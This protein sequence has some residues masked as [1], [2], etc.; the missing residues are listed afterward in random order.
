MKYLSKICLL[1]AVAL[2]ALLP[3]VALS[4]HVSASGTATMSLSPASTALAPGAS[5]NVDI[6]EDSGSDTVNAVQANLSYSSNLTFVSITSSPAFSI[7]AQ[8]S[9][10]GGSVKIGRGTSTPVSGD[11]IIATV[12]FTASGSGTATINFASGSAV[13]RS[14]DN[15]AEALTYN[16]GS[17][18]ISSNA[19]LT[20]SPST[21][22]V[23][24]GDNFDVSVYGDSGSAAVN[25]VQVNL[26][27]PSN[28]LTFVSSAGNTTTWPIE[29][30]NTGGSGTVKIGRGTTSPVSGKQL[31]ATVTFKA[32]AAGTASVAFTSGTGMVSSSDNTAVPSTNTGGIYTLTTSGTS[33]GGSTSG[34]GSTSTKS[35][36]S[37][38]TGSTPALPQS[39]TSAPASGSSPTTQAVDNTG[40]IISD[41]NVTDATADSATINWTTSEPA[42]SEVDYGLD[43]QYIITAADSKLTTSHSVKLDPKQLVSHKKYHFIV[44]SAD[45]SGNITVSDDNTFSTGGLQIT[46]T[47]VAV[48]AGGAALLGAGAWLA[49]AGGLKIG[50]AAAGGLK[51]GG[52]AGMF[53][54][55]TNSVAAGGNAPPSPDNIVKPEDG[56]TVIHP[57]NPGK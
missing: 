57:Q 36:S 56:G 29:A 20:L 28:L 51:I 30:Q 37:K 25:A 55:S 39:V 40:P 22:T 21:K 35:G 24:V 3:V 26:S 23:A 9:G 33:G 5:F 16:N 8:S 54:S 31:I 34:S 44:K 19:T 14:Q 48:G 27:Y 2:I 32:S 18:T 42:T 13:V 45:A 15:G 41:I 11:Q 38:S 4:N 17:Y 46:T 6:H 1:I 43:T 50:G 12:R 47:E 53:M 52:A 10:G 7:D 49:A